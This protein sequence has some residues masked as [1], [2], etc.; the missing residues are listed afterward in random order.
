MSADNIQ[1]RDLIA[2]FQQADPDEYVCFRTAE[3]KENVLRIHAEIAR[4]GSRL[5]ALT[6]EEPE[7]DEQALIKAEDNGYAGGFTDAQNL[8]LG[9]CKQNLDHEKHKYVIAAV[10]ELENPHE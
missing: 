8:A 10:S 7:P 4:A 1:I 3:N 2:L 6:V 5:W 9:I